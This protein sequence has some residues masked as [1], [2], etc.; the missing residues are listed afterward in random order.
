VRVLEPAF[1]AGLRALTRT[2]GAALILDEVQCGLGRT[3]ALFAHEHSGI[4]PDLMTLAKPLAG[5][6]PMGAVLMTAEIAAALKAGDHG[7]TFGG[8]PLVATVARYVLDRVSDPA[9]LGRVRTGGE[10]LGDALRAMAA[11]S[12]CVRAVRGIGFMWG[13][14]VMHP[15]AEVIAR[16]RES[17][18][19]LCSAGDYTIRLLPP[20][21]ATREELARGLDLLEGA[22]A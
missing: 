8:G 4:A 6:L 21:V 2:H 10:W 1:L 12:G 5:G 20:L 19:L 9:L 13:L 7:S 15:A 17:G 3:G 22:L 11:R 14:D 16:A 18:L